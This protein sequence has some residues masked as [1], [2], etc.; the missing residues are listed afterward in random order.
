MKIVANQATIRV[1]TLILP[2]GWKI[3]AG[4]GT[5]KESI[6]QIQELLISYQMDRCNHTWMG[7]HETCKMNRGDWN[8][9]RRVINQSKVKWAISMF[10]P[11]KSAGTDEIVLALLQHGIEHLVSHLCC[12]FRTCLAYGYISGASKQV[13]VMF[14]PKPGKT[15]YTKAKAY[16]SV[17]Q[18]VSHIFC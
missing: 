16:C 15:S 6:F 10:K 13:K 2:D 8:L 5:L 7:R 17:S 9:N 11:F 3:Q 4:K 1:S 12:R 14:I 18:S